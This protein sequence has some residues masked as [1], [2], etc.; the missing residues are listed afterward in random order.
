MWLLLIFIIFLYFNFSLKNLSFILFISWK[1]LT[2]NHSSLHRKCCIF[3]H[4]IFEQL[5]CLF[6]TT[7]MLS[8]KVP[9]VWKTFE[10]N[11]YPEKS[12]YEVFFNSEIV[13][14]SCQVCEILCGWK[15]EMK[16][17]LK[18]VNLLINWVGIE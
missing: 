15:M 18:I 6:S 17:L 9:F 11:I 4:I 10:K 2:K 12:W 1:M 7:F 14:F 3:W 8:S 16:L 13:D 5:L